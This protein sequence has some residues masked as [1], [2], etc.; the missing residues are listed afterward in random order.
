MIKSSE[1]TL[2]KICFIGLL[3]LCMNLWAQDEELLAVYEANIAS[4]ADE[5]LSAP[6]DISK[7]AAN[8][9]LLDL[10]P[11]VLSVEKVHKYPFEKVQ[12]MSILSTEDNKLRIFNWTLP[13]SNGTYEYFAYLHYYVK[14]EKIWKIVGLKDHS[15]FIDKPEQQQ[16]PASNWFGALYVDLISKKT[17]KGYIYTLIGWDGNRPTSIKKLV[18]VLSFDQAYN[19]RFGAPIFD[20][21]Q[22]TKHRIIFEYSP[23]ARI[24]VSYNTDEDMIIYDQLVPI[25]P[26]AE[27]VYEY[28]VP[29]LNY[30][31]IRFKDGYW[32]LVPNVQIN[33]NKEQDT[34]RFKKV[35]QG[36][37]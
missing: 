17:D 20:M 25:D 34:K 3:S 24:T 14:E 15:D 26:S 30:N 9:K 6:D 32:K 16:L 22:E 7:I 31:G 18:D 8:Q 11:E 12:S 28:Y 33:N 13:K 21:G 23:T 37:R 35:E 2:K 29:N 19:P 1:K 27:G 36:I 5:I 10:L 4:L